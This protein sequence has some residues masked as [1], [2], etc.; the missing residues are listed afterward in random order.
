MD[1]ICETSLTFNCDLNLGHGNLN[2]VFDT[3]SY[4]AYLY[5]KFFKFP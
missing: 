3:S 5:V 1:T 2:F 4:F